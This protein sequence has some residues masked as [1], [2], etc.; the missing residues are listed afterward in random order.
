MSTAYLVVALM[1]IAANAFSGVAAI[2]H[3][4]PITPAMARAGVG[5]R[6]SL[7]GRGRAGPGTDLALR[8]AA[9]GM[10]AAPA[11]QERTHGR[12]STRSPRDHARTGDPQDGLF[13]RG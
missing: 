11:S 10:K 13:S 1:A 3:F 6:V 12:K 4:K 9:P 7:A 5:D 8:D 2:V